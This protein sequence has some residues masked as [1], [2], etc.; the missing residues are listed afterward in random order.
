[1]FR[2]PSLLQIFMT[3]SLGA[4]ILS[5][6]EEG[7]KDRQQ[8]YGFLVH[9]DSSGEQ[10]RVTSYSMR[11]SIGDLE[12]SSNSTFTGKLS[13]RRKGSSV[14][15]RVLSDT[16]A[17]GSDEASYAAFKALPVDPAKMRRTTG[18]FEETA[19]ELSWATTCKEAVDSIADAIYRAVTDAGG[20]TVDFVKEEDIVSLEEAQKATTVM[21]KMEYGLKRLIWLG[22]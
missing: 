10:T 20:D 22:S 16:A 8:N 5:T 13:L 19:N 17:R 12:A 14:L 11:N 1:M 6:L 2:F 7:S 15:S 21:A 4:Y 3:S 18:S 9:Y